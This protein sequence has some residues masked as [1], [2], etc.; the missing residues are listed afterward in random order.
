MKILVLTE[1]INFGGQQ[2]YLINLFKE[3][4]KYNSNK[5]S[6][7]NL[8]YL[9]NEATDLEKDFKIVF[10]NVIH[11]PIPGRSKSI[12][13]SSPIKS[14]LKVIKTVKNISSNKYD[15]VFSNGFYS[16]AICVIL[17]LVQNKIRHVRL[18]GGDLARNEK[19]YFNSI[20]KIL[21]LYSYTDLVLAWPQQ[22]LFL[23]SMGI[24]TNTLLDFN[25]IYAVD[26]IL[27]CP[28]EETK[29][30]KNKLD[31]EFD[32]ITIGWVGRIAPDLEI[33]E[34]LLMCNY[35]SKHYPDFKYKLIIIGDGVGIDYLYKTISDLSLT[36]NF[37][38][39][40]FVQQADLP[41]YYSIIDFEVLLDHDPQGGSH[42]REAMACERVAVSV[43]GSS[44]VQA[45][46]IQNNITG[47]LVK[48]ENRIADA[49]F[50]IINMTAQERII[51]GR[52]ARNFIQNNSYNKLGGILSHYLSDSCN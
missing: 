9:F 49:A 8:G 15:V 11:F 4:K 21:P 52:N 32:A 37:I 48:P 36:S 41:K 7:L 6:E 40:P 25:S 34:T 47:I 43:D 39:I 26:S 2:F 50:R 29:D 38:H 19:F 30:L 20:L 24:N 5:N 3:Y 23:N 17:K 14:F 42:I 51:I 16:F 12:Y 18:I 45:T 22:I 10:N 27:F 44:G 46:L 13:F 33:N 31:I 28:H 35:I 1:G